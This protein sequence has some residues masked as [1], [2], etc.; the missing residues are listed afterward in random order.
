[1]KNEGR[2]RVVWESVSFWWKRGNGAVRRPAASLLFRDA[3]ARGHYNCC[4]G[5]ISSRAAVSLFR[6]LSTERLPKGWPCPLTQLSVPTTY[7]CFLLPHLGVNRLPA[8]ASL[9]HALQSE[10]RQISDAGT[11]IKSKWNG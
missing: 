5:N 7:S 3:G 9:V 2:P 1:M 10:G 8:N 6:Q 11:I 4:G